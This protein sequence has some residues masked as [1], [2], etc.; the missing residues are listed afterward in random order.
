MRMRLGDRPAHLAGG[1]GVV[2]RLQW[3]ASDTVQIVLNTVLG[4]V[5]VLMIPVALVT[6]LKRSVPFLVFLSLWALVAAHW[7]GALAAFAA[8]RAAETGPS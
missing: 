8:R 1:P 5:F 4:A 3:L 2:T 6:G 7:S